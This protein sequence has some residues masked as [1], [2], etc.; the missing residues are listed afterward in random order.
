MTDNPFKPIFIDKIFLY[1]TLKSDGIFYQLFSKFVLKNEPAYT[2]GT[3]GVRKGYPTF[4]DKGSYKVF[5]EL[6]HVYNIGQLLEFLEPQYNDKIKKIITVYTET[7]NEPIKAYCF[8][9]AKPMD[10][11]KIIES[12]YWDNKKAKIEELI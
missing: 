4:Y 3:L 10:G 6:I 7:A 9:C 1:G 2:I 11:V 5:G 12:G 8:V